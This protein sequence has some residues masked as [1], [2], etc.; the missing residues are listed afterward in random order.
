MYRALFLSLL[1]MSAFAAETLSSSAAKK[2]VKQYVAS[3]NPV[4]FLTDLVG[5]DLLK[6]PRDAERLVPVI[7]KALAQPL[8]PTSQDLTKNLDEKRKK[9]QG[10]MGIKSAPVAMVE[11]TVGPMRAICTGKPSARAPLLVYL[12]GGG[13][14]GTKHPGHL[15]NEMAWGW[16]FHRSRMITSTSAACIPRCISDTALNAW[17]LDT[18]IE[19]L[20]QTLDAYLRSF[21]V[22]G[23]RIYLMGTSMG[24]YGVWKAGAIEADRFAAIASL[25]AGCAEKKKT[26]LENL[27]S[28]SFGV[29]IGS[30]DRKRLK[31]AER[32]KAVLESLGITPQWT[33]YEGSGHA[34]PDTAYG[35]VDAFFRTHKRDPYPAQLR[36]H[37]QVSWKKRF[38]HLRIDKPQ[39][40]MSVN[41]DC[42]ANAINITS[43]KVNA[44]SIYL[45]DTLVNVDE[46]V[47]VTWNGT[48]V[49][50]D[51]PGR[52]LGV[53]LESL[54]E[55]S[56]ASQYYTARIDLK[57]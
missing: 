39:A 33:V 51:I 12:H 48:D 38:Y 27:A 49:Y 18:D 25:A 8:K 4:A 41:C 50:K 57:N 42:S 13:H 37:P 20:S 9:V 47:T 6:K 43:D 16:G 2:I 19:A 46:I 52:H 5:K 28:T 21:P 10:M 30:K 29:F 7:L 24:G 3:D 34:L 54:Q 32:G 53:L 17:I 35:D 45:N 1:L 40:G 11:T 14:G 22:D 15:D 31:E 56:D 23:N 26:A 36:W 55:R 44:L